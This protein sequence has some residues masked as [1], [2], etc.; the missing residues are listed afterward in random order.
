MITRI[1]SKNTE[2]RRQPLS[3]VRNILFTEHLLATASGICSMSAI[4]TT[5]RSH[6]ITHLANSSQT[7]RN[8]KN[9]GGAGSL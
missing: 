3:D 5:E 6:K 4:K 7:L 8:E 1:N 2:C 9:S